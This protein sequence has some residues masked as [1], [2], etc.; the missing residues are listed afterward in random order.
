M[1]ISGKSTMAS[2]KLPTR[3]YAEQGRN[4][5]SWPSGASE[6]PSTPLPPWRS[7]RAGMQ[8]IIYTRVKYRRKSLQE[9]GSCGSCPSC[10]LVHR[11]PSILLSE[12][13]HECVKLVSFAQFCG[14]RL[15]PNTSHKLGPDPDP[16]LRQS[17]SP[18]T[19]H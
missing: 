9:Q 8:N 12:S 1:L 7:V 13:I 4:V 17:L 10:C 19:E 2:S 3:C 18:N 15:S 16:K 11:R 5:H 6:R 14:F